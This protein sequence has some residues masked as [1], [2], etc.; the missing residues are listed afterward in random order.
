MKGNNMKPGTV[1]CFKKKAGALQFS[2]LLPTYNE[3]GYVEREGC[4]MAEMA[5][6]LE[7]SDNCDWTNK[8][9][10]KLGTP[11]LLQMMTA[12]KTKS[13][14]KLYHKTEK[15]ST[16]IDFKPGSE[17]SFNWTVRK[18]ADDKTNT[19]MM[20]LSVQDCL[21]IVTLF[22]AAIPKIYGW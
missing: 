15:S 10:V 5:K 16:A 9:I 22:E 8:I 6:C 1:Q 18:M 19:Y 21:L 2:L 4:I 11:D 20:Y 7:N 12:L 17:G 13:A 14:I 3:K